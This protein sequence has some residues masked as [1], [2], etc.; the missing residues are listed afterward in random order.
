VTLRASSRRAFAA[1][2]TV[3]GGFLL[4]A[5][6]DDA[7]PPPT[8]FGGDTARFRRMLVAED[9]RG[10]GPDALSPLFEG[11]RSPVPEV[12]WWAVRAVGR[13]ED[14]AAIPEIVPLLSDSIAY[15]RANAA[16]AMAQAVVRADAS[17]ARTHLLQRI[18][19][20]PHP[21]VRAVLA[22]SIGR[23]R[24]TAAQDV[25][26][27]LEL[28]LRLS[29]D[30][31]AAAGGAADLVL[32][33]VRGLYFL[34]RQPDV[35]A[36]G[37][38]PA[39][40]NRLDTLAHFGGTR[41]GDDPATLTAQRIRSIA[42]ATM[43]IVG[44]ATGPRLTAILAD[45]SPLVRREGAVAAAALRDSAAMRRIAEAAAADTAAMVRYE[46]LRLLGRMPRAAADCARFRDAAASP[47]QPHVAILALDLLG[48]R[49]PD[50]AAAVAL[51]DRVAGALPA[52]AS[53]GADNGERTWH[54]PAHALV[55]LAAADARQAAARL[56]AFAA[57][58]DFFVRMYAARV[59]ATLRDLPA[60]TALARDAHPNVRAEAVTG[61]RAS[62]GHAADDI[63]IAQLEQDDGQ[64]VMAAA[65]ALEGT[66]DTAALPALLDALDRISVPRRETSRD[67]RRAL[68]D[69]I[70]ALGDSTA[71]PRIESYL[72]DF[73]RA[74]AGAA[75]DVLE[76]WTGVRPTPR[77]EPLTPMPLPSLAE[78]EALDTTRAILT[79]ANGDTIRLR[80][81]PFEAPTNVARF[82]RLAREGYFDGLTIHRVVPNFVV[83]GGSPGANEF[84]GDGPFTRDELG[85]AFNWRGTVG[86][87][88]RGR[89]TGDG[90]LYIN[91][92][93]NVR[94]DHDYTVWA[95]VVTGMDAVDRILE[96]A[97]IG[98]V[99]VGSPGPVEED[100]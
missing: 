34:V 73:D 23:L 53:D 60:L 13:L 82:V 92:V 87:S 21:A 99:T 52:G 31:T 11:V 69:R 96:G 81:L 6:A 4:P 75:A 25:A 29:R 88:T 17:L 7:A 37:F 28:L 42:V 40:G 90:Q 32:G 46:G 54:Q 77:P 1:C 50:D 79:L 48:P 63:Y 41:A 86:L 56:P 85:F 72:T 9:T 22:E 55:A 93:D 15:V 71:A 49:C 10:R 97:L 91:L 58:P 98:S 44:G 35:R 2:L 18:D 36:A 51:L 89:D 16:Q 24:H 57:H 14:A 26:T 20:E 100:R 65:G 12:R 66:T 64:L 83:Q 68:L 27:S 84:A 76:R 8:R 78:L 5:C 80:L 43:A 95:E 38:A 47:R 67:A 94:L 59:A 62:A 61:L 33:A 3:A 70:A 19:V 39:V 45:L 30:S 74:I